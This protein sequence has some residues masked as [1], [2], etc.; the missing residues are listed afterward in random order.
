M[1]VANGDGESAVVGAD[2]VHVQ[3]V[4]AT[5]INSIMLFY[6]MIHLVTF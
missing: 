6:N 5:G 1:V 3:A 2:D 4:S